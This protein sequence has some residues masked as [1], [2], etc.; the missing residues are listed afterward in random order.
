LKGNV[1]I[2]GHP[3]ATIRAI[4]QSFFLQYESVAFIFTAP[5]VVLA[6]L[7]A[8]RL[9]RRVLLV[10]GVFVLVFLQHLCFAKTGWFFRYEAYL[11]AAQIFVIG[12]MIGPILPL[13]ASAFFLRLK[14]PLGWTCVP[15]A[16]A[17]ILAQLR[18]G[19]DALRETPL[20]MKNI[21]DQQCQM[22]AFVD[23]FYGGSSVAANDIG[24]LSYLTKARITDLWGLTDRTVF[25]AK[26]AGNYDTRV[27]QRV[28]DEKHVE[29]AMVYDR[30]FLHR[31][32]LPADWRRVGSF[33]MEFNV[34]CGSDTVAVYALN[35]EAAQKLERN[36]S[37][38]AA[39]VPP[40]VHV[41]TRRGVAPRDDP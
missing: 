13:Q 41:T 25:K 1:P 28:C 30:W 33:Q 40:D 9:E 39:S 32:A 8:R 10:L 35:S 20:A 12:L 18:Y 15:V 26:L 36:L 5:L 24:A 37:E 27:I 7:S 14:Q 22:A 2:N 29:I 11:R 23:R 38:F 34:I 3:L 17:I 21:Y 31:E 4:L 6:I 16:L 19:Y